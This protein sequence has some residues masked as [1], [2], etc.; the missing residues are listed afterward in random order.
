MPDASNSAVNGPDNSTCYHGGR[1]HPWE[2]GESCP[3]DG[4]QESPLMEALRE[5][6]ARAKCVACNSRLRTK[7]DLCRECD[8]ELLGD[9]SAVGTQ[10][11]RPNQAGK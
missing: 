9:T 4:P 1:S 6:V 3:P 5:Y 11:I 10:V 7:G 2:P 8:A